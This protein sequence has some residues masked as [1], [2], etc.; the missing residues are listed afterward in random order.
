[1][2]C[3][4]L[5]IIALFAVL[6]TSVPGHA[7]IEPALPS[8][9]WDN[10][11]VDP[12]PWTPSALNVIEITALALAVDLYFGGRVSGTAYR[13][14]VGA[15]RALFGGSAAPATRASATAVAP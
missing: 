11:S 4:I 6:L 12:T 10:P 1:M 5:T 13:A 3:R 9:N 8:W 2:K 7:Q 15:G 14:V